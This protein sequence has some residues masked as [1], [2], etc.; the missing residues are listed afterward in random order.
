METIQ[1][2]QCDVRRGF[3]EGGVDCGG[4]HIQTCWVPFFDGV[5][6]LGRV[7]YDLDTESAD[8]HLTWH[9]A[10][11][12]VVVHSPYRWLECEEQALAYRERMECR[13]EE[14][15][16]RLYTGAVPYYRF[17]HTKDGTTLIEILE[18]LF[19]GVQRVVL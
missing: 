18:V 15:R 9:A 1:T 5:E 12:M 19:G 7:G 6:V 2:I 8:F 17:P 16:Q 3:L 13:R 10:S 14:D 11:Q 4:V